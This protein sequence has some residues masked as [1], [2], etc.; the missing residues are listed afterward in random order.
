MAVLRP[1][2]NAAGFYTM[3]RR[4]QKLVVA[5]VPSG[6]LLIA[7]WVVWL[8]PRLM[9]HGLADGAWADFSAVRHSRVGGDNVISFRVLTGEALQRMIQRLEFGPG[10]S[11]GDT[12]D[13]ADALLLSAGFYPDK[14]DRMR[15]AL[16]WQGRDAC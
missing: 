14:Y 10:A 11:G 3:L 13:T 9:F 6:I 7:V 1:L 15:G 8:S 4:G 2:A 12:G 5:A 16:S